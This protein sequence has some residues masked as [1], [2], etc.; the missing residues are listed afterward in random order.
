MLM[1]DTYQGAQLEKH[2]AA[3]C[4]MHASWKCSRSLPRIGMRFGPPF[5]HASIVVGENKRGQCNIYERRVCR[6]QSMQ[7]FLIS[8]PFIMAECVDRSILL[9]RRPIEPAFYLTLISSL[10]HGEAQPTSDMIIA[11]FNSRGQRLCLSWSNK[12]WPWQKKC[13]HFFTI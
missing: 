10:L 8:Y 1:P 4:M 12:L 9:S 11:D 2:L 7:P 5:S 6:S 13:H 3:F